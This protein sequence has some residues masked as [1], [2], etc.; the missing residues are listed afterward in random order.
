MA[1]VLDHFCSARNALAWGVLALLTLSGC[2]AVRE[3]RQLPLR[4]LVLDEATGRP[5][6][7][8]ILLVRSA[9]SDG[10]HVAYRRY[11]A[12][13][14]GR[15]VAPAVRVWSLHP[16]LKVT[17]KPA[18]D[19]PNEH[20]YFAPGHAWVRVPI[21]SRLGGRPPDRVYLTPLGPDAPRA[22]P[23][24]IGLRSWSGAQTWEIDLPRCHA[25]AQGLREGN[26][27]LVYWD[28]RRV[29]LASSLR[30]EG[31]GLWLEGGPGVVRVIEKARWESG[32]RA[33][34]DMERCT[35]R[36]EK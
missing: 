22:G 31:G 18:R 20:L 6:P 4:G 23:D 36:I 25:F 8:A 14:E 10:S 13:D 30:K 11:D 7:R 1:R 21:G 35:L 26:G 19:W 9:R 3:T 17:L 27:L 16:G 32:L 24:A 12:D 33:F 5:I 28:P 29:V 34:L 2:I 15:L